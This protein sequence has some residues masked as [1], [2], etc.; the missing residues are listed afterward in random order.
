[1][2]SKEEEAKR[3]AVDKKTIQRDLEDIRRYLGEG[4][5]TEG[6][7]GPDYETEFVPD[8]E[9]THPDSQIPDHG[10]HPTP[11]LQYDRKKKGYVLNK[12]QEHALTNEE[13]LA[14]GK[15][16]LESRA[17]PKNEMA[18]LI[19]KLTLQSTAGNRKHIKEVVRNEAFHYIPLQHDKNLLH[20]IWDVTTAIRT[21][22][23]L[24][25]NY[26]REKAIVS[27]DAVVL[28]VGLVFSEYYFYL[29]AYK[30]KEDMPFPIIYRLDRIQSYTIQQEHFKIPEKDRFEEGEFR[31]K[32]QF[33]TPGEIMR[34]HFYFQGPSIEAVLDRLPT[35]K[36][37]TK[38]GDKFLVEAE[39]FG[40]GIKMWLLSQ[41]PHL[42]VVKPAHFRE[43]METT[44]LDMHHVYSGG[45]QQS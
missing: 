27:K 44:I 19:H 18:N 37:L 35:A 12:Q 3:F 41:G 43:R 26:K 34:I 9:H 42:E 39:V 45:G 22:R 40:E 7:I 17:F 20:L 21:H 23:K 8:Q 11:Y 31:K 30:E 5:R 25:I 10:T 24:T 16:L 36:I 1:M 15:V 33:M 29:I 14:I 28:P 4:K 2:I 38:T 6:A 13:I 32:I